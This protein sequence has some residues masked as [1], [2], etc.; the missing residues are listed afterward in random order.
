MFVVSRLW[1]SEQQ[2]DAETQIWKESKLHYTRNS[3]Q[4]F[5]FRHNTNKAVSERQG[6]EFLVVKETSIRAEPSLTFYFRH[7]TRFHIASKYHFLQPLLPRTLIMDESDANRSQTNT[8]PCQQFAAAGNCSGCQHEHH[9]NLNPALVGMVSPQQYRV[10]NEL[11]LAC[12]SCLEN[13]REVSCTRADFRILLTWHSATS[14]PTIHQMD[15][16]LA[17]NAVTSAVKKSSAHLHR[18]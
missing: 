3:L 15:V 9:P 18:T 14:S 13:L 5:P 16:I 10:P 11:G 4:R 17:Q 7:N 1:R 8:I 2:V 6:I 12:H